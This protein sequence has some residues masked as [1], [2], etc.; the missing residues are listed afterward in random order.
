MHMK[1]LSLAALAFLLLRTCAE[2]QVVVEFNA[3]LSEGAAQAR[4]AVSERRKKPQ[5][6]LLRYGEACI[7]RAVAAH[8]GVALRPDIPAPA[9]YYGSKTP[10]K[11]FQDAVEPQWNMRPEVFLNAYIVAKNEVYL[12]DEAE[13]YR[14]MKRALDD[15]L[16][17]EYAHYIQVKYKGF[18]L[19]GDDSLEGQ[20]VSEQT[21]FRETFIQQDPPADFCR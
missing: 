21:W 11:Q 13:Y 16:A 6:A 10:L 3:A 5:A 2:A 18:S 7:L 17:H 1:K 8:M 4:A 20:A 9:V 12:L 19:E 14:R 15:S